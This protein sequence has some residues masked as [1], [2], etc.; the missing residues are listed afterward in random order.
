M[1]TLDLSVVE[2]ILRPLIIYI[3]LLAAIRIGG[4]RELGQSNILQFVLLLAVANA[5]QNGIIG[6]DNS[7]IGA[8][9]GAI[10]LFTANGLVELIASRNRK[11]H[12]LVIGRP[13]DLITRGLI[14]HR[15]LRRQRL[16]EDDLQ[17]AAESAGLR[18]VQDIE[19]AVL[20]PSGEILVSPKDAQSTSDQIREL[21]KKIDA[22]IAQLNKG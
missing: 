13:V 7:I 8:L 18:N 22:L 20:T 21:N 15:T 17:V 6:A 16:N 5:V 19:H 10:T 4:Q 14:N 1:F 3:F 2:K 11:F 9:I 12:N